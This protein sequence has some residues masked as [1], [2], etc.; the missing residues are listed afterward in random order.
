MNISNQ[1]I[2]FSPVFLCQAFLTTDT[3][4]DKLSSITTGLPLLRSPLPCSTLRLRALS[5]EP[6]DSTQKQ[7]H[8][9]CKFKGLSQP[10][11]FGSKSDATSESFGA[12]VPGAIHSRSVTFGPG[13]THQLEEQ[14]EPES[15]TTWRVQPMGSRSHARMP[16]GE[17]QICKHSR[18]GIFSR[19]PVELTQRRRDSQTRGSNSTITKS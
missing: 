12:D 3:I 18:K 5:W 13:H 15:L 8:G 11:V 19:H 9:G 1:P 7:K 2:I 14:Q 10:C 4:P 6:G 17:S 16:L